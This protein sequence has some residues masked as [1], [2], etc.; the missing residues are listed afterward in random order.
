MSEESK[1]VEQPVNETPNSVSIDEFNAL[2]EKV[3][4]L[5]STNER[6][7]TESKDYKGKYRA[8]QSDHDDK[9]A[10]DLEANESWQERLEIE[11]TKNFELQNSIN[12]F[13]QM[14]LKS[15]LQN[16]VMKLAPDAHNV[17]DIINSLGMD[18]IEINEDNLSFGGLDDA[19]NKVR[20]SKDY[21]FKKERAP[22]MKQSAPKY[23]GGV[24]SQ[25][26][27]RVEKVNLLNNAILN[28]TGRT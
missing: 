5:T 25:S 23:D 12:D 26:E 16:E 11:K 18:G 21:L 14:Q 2:Q 9:K 1:M 6:I 15:N 28:V 3:K 27:L 19:V 17:N 10:A 7:L 8:L 24:K 13:K 4:S 22:Q 20:E